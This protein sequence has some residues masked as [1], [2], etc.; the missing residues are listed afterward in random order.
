MKKSVSFQVFTNKFV[1]ENFLT[2]SKTSDF[3]T[4]SV[5]SLIELTSQN[6]L[7]VNFPLS[8]GEM[9][10]LNA[11][12]RWVMHDEDNRLQHLAEVHT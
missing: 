10:V 9:D 12:R 7:V 6:D 4:L 2:V 11:V 1:A 5:G 3:M 8:T